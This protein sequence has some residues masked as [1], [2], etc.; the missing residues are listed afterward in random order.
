MCKCGVTLGLLLNIQSQK[1]A[2]LCFCKLFTLPHMVPN[3]KLRIIHHDWR[4]CASSSD[5]STL[6]HLVSSK[7][8]SHNGQRFCASASDKP[9]HVPPGI[10]QDVQPQWPDSRGSVLLQVTLSHLVSGETFSHNGQRFCASA[11]D[12]IFE[13]SRSSR[14]GFLNRDSL[15]ILVYSLAAKM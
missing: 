8:F 15:Q 11:G 3:K 14:D 1:P 5:N 6:S 2:V 10:S 13:D 12:D 4:F 7:M 9:H